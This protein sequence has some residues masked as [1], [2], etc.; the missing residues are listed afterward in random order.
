M[1][2]KQSKISVTPELGVNN[3]LESFP[4][5]PD[6]VYETNVNLQDFSLLQTTN[7]ALRCILDGT[8]MINTKAEIK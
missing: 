1:L 5:N 2:E 4:D 3:K 8:D 7:E 6:V